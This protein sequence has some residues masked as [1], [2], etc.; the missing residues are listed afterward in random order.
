[1]VRRA[2]RLLQV[3]LPPSSA[4]SIRLLWMNLALATMSGHSS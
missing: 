3:S 2:G 1:M 4:E